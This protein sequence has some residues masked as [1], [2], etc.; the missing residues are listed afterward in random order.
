MSDKDLSR[1][2]ELQQIHE[3]RKTINQAAIIPFQK[4]KDIFQ[5]RESSRE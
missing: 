1:Y 3:K 4:N 5:L 2:L